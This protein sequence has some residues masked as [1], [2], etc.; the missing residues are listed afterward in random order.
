MGSDLDLTL[1]RQDGSE[2]AVDVA[3]APLTLDGKTWIVVAIRDDS[4]QRAAEHVRPTPSCTPS[5]PSLL[6]PRC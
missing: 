5:P 6:P 1:L 2:L 3:L 4:A